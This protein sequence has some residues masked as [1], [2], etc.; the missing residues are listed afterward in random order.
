MNC[1]YKGSITETKIILECLKQELN[2]SV[3]YGDKA[4]YDLVIDI[5]NHLYRIQIKTSRLANTKGKAFMFNCYSTINGK[6]RKYTKD[7]IDYFATI[8]EEQLYLIPV[9]EC[10][11][12]KTLWLDTPTISSCC[13][14]EKYLF[15]EVVK[16]L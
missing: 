14:A 13:L 12:E 10:S 8:W 2:I 15:K 11:S 7:E 16:T 1:N 9:E 4:R 5:N 3:P 6:R